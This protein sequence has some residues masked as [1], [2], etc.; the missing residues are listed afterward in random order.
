M[1]KSAEL[2]ETILTP[3]ICNV[4]RMAWRCISSWSFHRSSQRRR[5][6]DIFRYIS[7]FLRILSKNNRK[8]KRK[9]RLKARKH[10]ESE[11]R[12]PAA[13]IHIKPNRHNNNLYDSRENHHKVK[14]LN[15]SVSLQYSKRNRDFITINFQGVFH[16]LERY[17]GFEP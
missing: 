15:Y 7:R 2:H 11:S 16:V 13:V 12:N 3:V 14:I 5:E 4:F 6:M 9:P 1:L 10:W 8:K 17:I